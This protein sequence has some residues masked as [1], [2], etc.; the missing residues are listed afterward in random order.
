MNKKII[1]AAITLFI[2]QC[3]AIH[4][5]D[6]QQNNSNPNNPLLAAIL[7]SGQYPEK[8][9]TEQPVTRKAVDKPEAPK[10]PNNESILLAAQ[11]FFN[12]LYEWY[13]QKN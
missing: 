9:P 2:A 4:D 7:Q 5:T 8:Q 1:I 6:M 3:S 12:Q 11:K 10:A 13:Y